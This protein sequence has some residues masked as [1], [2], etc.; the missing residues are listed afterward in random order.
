[1]IQN[2]F[3]ATVRHSRP[4]VRGLFTVILL[5]ALAIITGCQ[6]ADNQLTAL[7]QQARSHQA[8]AALREGDTIRIA[9]PGTPTLNPNPQQIRP[10]GKITLPLLGEMSVVGMTPSDLEKELVNRYADKLVSKEVTV[11]VESASFAVYVTGAVLRPGKISSN[12]TL[13][14]LDAIMEAG[15]FDYAKANMKG[16]KIVRHEGDQIK[17]FTVNLRAA[18]QGNE[19]HPFY[20]E[21]G[22]IVY[23]SERFSWY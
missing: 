6:S 18:L 15:G 9:F 13:T 8:A 10:D 20:L 4:W 12:H 22:D 5:P 1:M 17:H 16:V 7:D 23:V 2:I 11:T 3:A 21:P 19:S 14:A